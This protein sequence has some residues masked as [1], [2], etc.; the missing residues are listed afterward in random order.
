MSYTDEAAFYAQVSSTFEYR[1]RVI[2]EYSRNLFTMA[3]SSK[4]RTLDAF[5]KPPPQKVK[6]SD[7]E[8]SSTATQEFKVEEP[9]SWMDRY[10]CYRIF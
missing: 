5:F 1:T 10:M 4:K 2:G 9:V 6:V 8:G 7:A 3:E